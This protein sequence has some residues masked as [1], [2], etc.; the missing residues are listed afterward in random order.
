M[1]DPSTS[2][3]LPQGNSKRWLKE[4]G[5]PLYVP[6]EGRVAL[7]RLNISSPAALLIELRRLSALGV[8]WA[9]AALAT[10][11]LYPDERGQREL[12]RCKEPVVRA[13]EAGDPYSLCVLAWAELLAGEGSACLAHLNRS[14]KAGFT[15]AI[16]D[17]AATM[18]TQNLGTALRLLKIAEAKGHLAARGRI[19][20]LWMRGKLGWALRAPGLVWFVY[21]HVKTQV[22][23]RRDPLSIRTFC[24]HDRFP[25]PPIRRQ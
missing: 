7:S 16:L 23:L 12:S 21:N 6:P 2:T 8:S 19:L 1:N 17:L 25:S 14:A 5:I 18:S 9:S 10:I 15:P 22:N 24:I 11:L 3:L 20:E 4:V 13:A